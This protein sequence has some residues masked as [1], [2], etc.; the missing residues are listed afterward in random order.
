[1]LTNVS[2]R[3]GFCQALLLYNWSSPFRRKASQGCRKHSFLSWQVRCAG[4]SGSR[5]RRRVCM[6]D[7][8]GAAGLSSLGLVPANPRQA[9]SKEAA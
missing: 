2:D 4:G 3:W 1:M 6:L 7:R 9:G 5:E 8:P